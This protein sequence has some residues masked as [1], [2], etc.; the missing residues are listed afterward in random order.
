M[1]GPF[2]LSTACYGLLQ[3]GVRKILGIGFCRDLDLFI[4]LRAEHSGAFSAAASILL[5][6]RI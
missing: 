2:F 4:L 6:G 5:I 3:W 1:R